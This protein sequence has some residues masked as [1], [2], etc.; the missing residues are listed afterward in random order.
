MISLNEL[1]TLLRAGHADFELIRQDRPIRSAADAAGYYPVEKSA[2]TLVLDS[3]EGLV[4]C[5][6]SV[7]S[8]RL[9]LES[10]A[11]RFGYAR[12]KLAHSG[13]IEKETGYRVGSVPLIGHALPCIFDER[14]MQYDYVYGGT[15]DELVTLK[16][17]PADVRRL[18]RIVH[19]L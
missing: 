15:G 19:V 4:A 7:G 13:K 8:G 2:P 16:I 5:I 18:N 14:L 11:R 10:A 12:L 6:L 1:E 9:D 17:A 3:G